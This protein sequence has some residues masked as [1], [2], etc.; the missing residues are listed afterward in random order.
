MIY[1]TVFVVLCCTLWLLSVVLILDRE[2]LEDQAHR[3]SWLPRT[4]PHR[5]EQ[6]REKQ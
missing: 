2:A 1:F 6:L 4:D 5:A 3:D